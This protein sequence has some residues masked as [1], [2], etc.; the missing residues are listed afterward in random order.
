[1][2]IS[3]EAQDVIF[4]LLHNKMSQL[5]ESLIFVNTCP[6]STYDNEVDIKSPHDVIDDAIQF[7][8]VNVQVLANLPQAAKDIAQFTCCNCIAHSILQYLVSDRV[9]QVNVLFFAR[10]EQDCRALNRYAQ[11]TEVS[12]L[13][14]CFA[15]LHETAQ[16][17]TNPE[18]AKI[19]ADPALRRRLFPKLD[20]DKL[21]VLMEKHVQVHVSGSAGTNLPNFDKATAKVRLCVCIHIHTYIHTYTYVIH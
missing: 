10:L 2:K 8:T 11:S 1:M 21:A 12:H 14:L 19:S 15:E 20:P 13:N 6:E 5:L 18:L 3:L 4:E 17:C 7:L 16:A 9:K